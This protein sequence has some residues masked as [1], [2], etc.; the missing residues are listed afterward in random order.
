MLPSSI[1]VETTKHNLLQRQYRGNSRKGIL[2]CYNKLADPR[3]SNVV[4]APV[5]VSMM[6]GLG[7]NKMREGGGNPRF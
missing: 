7:P 5:G 4:V 3:G 1:I 6:P 2:L